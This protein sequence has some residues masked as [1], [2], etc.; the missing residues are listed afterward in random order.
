MTEIQPPQET[1]APQET[2]PPQPRTP[3]GSAGSAPPSPSVGRLVAVDLARALAVFGM[4]VVHIGPRLSATDGVDS[5]VRYLADGRSS[6]LFAT[7][8]GFSLMLIAGRLKPKT[9]LAGRQAKARIAIRAVMLVALGTALCMVYGD[10]VIVPFYGVYFLL[11]LP[12][13]RL[14]ARTLAIIAAALALV[15]PQLAFAV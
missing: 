14:R 3:P 13:V 12:L 15:T 8:A 7:L 6:V 2:S 10:L 4:Y 1:S 11:A 5:W 9:G